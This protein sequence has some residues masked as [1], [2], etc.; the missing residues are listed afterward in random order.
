MKTSPLFT[1]KKISLSSGISL[2]GFVGDQLM[3]THLHFEM[4]AIGASHSHPHEQLTIVLQGSVQFTL[5]EESNVLNAG[6]AVAIP[7]NSVH[8]LVAL[9]EA[10]V[11]D[12]FTPVRADLVEK[13]SLRKD[14]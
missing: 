13:L 14:S 1:N 12:I 5:G 6:D 7:S 8:G 4:G 3:V 2:T 9:T 11:L 10:E